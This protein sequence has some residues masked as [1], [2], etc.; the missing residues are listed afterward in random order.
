MSEGKVNQFVDFESG[1]DTGRN[2]AASIEPYAD[3]EDVIEGVLDRPL[4]HL[5]TRSEILRG[6]DED[7]LYLRDADRALVLG[8]P[9][10]ITWSGPTTDGGSTLGDFTLSDNLYIMPMA[11]P[12]YPQSAPIPPVASQYGYLILTET[13]ASAGVLVTSRRRNYERGDRIS[14]E[15]V[16]GGSP[17]TVSAALSDP[18][19]AGER[20]IVVTANAPTLT[21]TL[22]ALNGVTADSP[23]TQL[24]TATLHAGAPGTD[25]L[26]VPQARQY[27]EFNYDG[28]GHAITPTV[29]NSFFAI[30]LFRLAEGDSL[31]IQYSKVV[32]DVHSSHSGRRES[33]P[34]NSN[35]GVLSTMMFNS[36]VSPGMLVNC[37]PI[38]KV[39]SGRLI[40]FNGLSI[41][42][43]TSSSL[44]GPVPHATTHAATGTDPIDYTA[45]NGIVTSGLQIF[46]LP[47]S[48]GIST[49][50]IMPFRA[51][52]G[53]RMHEHTSTDD[54]TNNTG[55]ILD[56][57]VASTWYY[58][59]AYWTGSALT[60]EYST[61]PPESSGSCKAGDPTRL[62]LCAF[63]TTSTA[64]IFSFYR[65]GRRTT[66]RIDMSME[67]ADDP[68]Y[69]YVQ[70]H[71][72]DTNLFTF[73][74]TERIPPSFGGGITRLTRM[75]FI[76]TSGSAGD[77]T[78]VCQGASTREGAS[79]Y[80]IYQH[81]TG[82]LL[83]EYV[84]DVPV[85]INQEIQIK[86]SANGLRA[87][88]F[89]LS[90]ED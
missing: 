47:P 20:T 15:V 44:A 30:N 36:R 58:L 53:G 55:G 74:F 38:C 70:T 86:N 61:T 45:L 18:S 83:F 75:M 27:I 46:S 54:I 62:Y 89:V 69:A 80:L 79:K 21:D 32:D 64:Y 39:V 81:V 41:A 48:A 14:V 88:A 71:T 52:I 28:E 29:I 17:G 31:C 19:P 56:G 4:E 16:L 43:G 78:K 5:R 10:R 34:E 63:R 8:G 84:L 13:G 42:A 60:F 37:L 50:R 35:T 73:S 72:G 68:S 24:V 6:I 1:S 66:Y 25:I 82:N 3:G 51:I 9:G 7:T 49:I 65:Q 23:A 87:F 2:N 12:G 59:Y 11:T 57:I 76:L 77:N 22:A 85:D 40:F 26:T 33:I 67:A 90:Y